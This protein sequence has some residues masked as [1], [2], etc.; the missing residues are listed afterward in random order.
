MMKK[1]TQ[2][3]E[4]KKQ[5]DLNYYLQELD[6]FP[7]DLKKA[8]NKLLAW[9][10]EDEVM[11]PWRQ[12]W[13]QNQDPYGIW[14]SEIMLQQT[15]IKAVIPKYKLFMKQFPTVF[16]LAKAPEENVKQAVSG[17]GYYRRFALLHKGAK[18]LVDAAKNKVN[19]KCK[20]IDGFWPK[21]ANEWKKVPGVGDYTS[22]AIA[23]ICLGEPVGVVDGNVERV[24]CRLWDIRLPPNLS[25]LKKKFKYI[26]DQWIDKK[27]PGA[28]NQGI[29]ELGQTICSKATP[30]CDICPL[31][32]DCFAKKNASTH[33]APQ[34]KKAQETVELDLRLCILVKNN[35]IGLIER[36]AKAR[37]LKNTD[38]FVTSLKVG[39]S[40]AIDGFDEIGFKHRDWRASRLLGSFSHRITKHKLNCEVYR[41]DCSQ[42]D[43]SALKNLKIQWFDDEKTEK[44]LIAS[45]DLKALQIWKK[46]RYLLTLNSDK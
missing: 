29:M 34:N 42:I 5:K 32:N 45:L 30:S 31:K 26:M 15:V 4:M 7:F 36:A 41:F 6:E 46:Q 8:A 39:K 37:F 17:L 11:H 38:G 13:S 44:K 22:A 1:A 43:V 24:L 20:T 14:V 18:Q 16:D 3:K 12:H 25:D 27:H 21:S 10:Q 19:E 40:F 33:L 2:S 9:Y 35:K 28:F 23:S